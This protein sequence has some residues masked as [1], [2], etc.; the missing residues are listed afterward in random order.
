MG[1][2]R[3]QAEG[4]LGSFILPPT[5]SFLLSLPSHFLSF[6]PFFFSNYIVLICVSFFNGG[7]I[8]MP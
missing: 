7:V 8:H 2:F 5:S 1:V 3:G 4:W 6:F